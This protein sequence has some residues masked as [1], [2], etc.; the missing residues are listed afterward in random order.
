MPFFSP[1]TAACF[2][3]FDLDE[4]NHLA[5]Y[6]MAGLLHQGRGIRGRIVMLQG[7]CSAASST[8]TTLPS[9]RWT[10]GL[11]TSQMCGR[12]QVQLFALLF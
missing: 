7:Y 4:A 10:S 11:A 8:S 12:K 2:G 5:V 6:W 1:E 3:M 9:P